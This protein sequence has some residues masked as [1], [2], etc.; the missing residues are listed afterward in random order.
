MKAKM[1]RRERRRLLA[2]NKADKLREEQTKATEKEFR[3]LD[4]G[5][6]AF[7]MLHYI[8]VGHN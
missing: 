6:E 4:A 7:N 2:K 5:D 8:Q 3:G 1:V